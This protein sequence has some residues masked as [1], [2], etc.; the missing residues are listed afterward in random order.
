MSDLTSPAISEPLVVID[1]VG[2]SFGAVDV[3]KEVSLT[4]AAGDVLSLIGPSGSGKT[5]LLRCVNYLETYER[6]LITIAGESVGVEQLPDGRRR[7]KSDRQIAALRAQV[8]M[9]FQHYN[10][11]PHLD[12]LENLTVAPCRVHGEAPAQVRE[13]ALALLERVGLADKRHRYPSE[14]SG[15]QQQR[16][17]IA[18][19]LT[20]QP[21]L[22]LLDEVTSALDPE[23]V[24]EVLDVITSL[25]ADGI[26]M[27]I[28]THEMAFAREVST[29][30][31]FMADGRLIES[32]TPEAIFETPAHE[33]LRSFMQRYRAGSRL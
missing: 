4:V 20:M 18:R 17:A 9:V 30:V 31:A 8:G 2:K 19:A 5:T 24:G 16:V 32:G 22:L 14:L 12:V 15:G 7:R 27:M 11:F 6:G 3:L 21:R 33:R 23:L 25:A 29:S 13:R 28:V 26:T 1:R 10:L